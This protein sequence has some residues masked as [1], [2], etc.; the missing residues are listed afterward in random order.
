MRND[1]S[2]ADLLRVAYDDER[3]R[4]E[5]CRSV[6]K[7]WPQIRTALKLGP[8]HPAAESAVD[9]IK[10]ILHESRDS[11][12]TLTAKGDHG[13][14]PICVFGFDQLCTVWVPEFDQQGLF[15]SHDDA[16]DYACNTWSEFLTDDAVL[17]DRFPASR[18]ADQRAKKRAKVKALQT[19]LARFPIETHEYSKVGRDKY[20]R[21]PRRQYEVGP[22][23][24]GNQLAQ[25]LVNVIGSNLVDLQKQLKAT[26][27][28]DLI[29]KVER[30][31]A[32]RMKRHETEEA[33]GRAQ[34]TKAVVKFFDNFLQDKNS[35]DAALLDAAAHAWVWKGFD[36]DE[37][38]PDYEDR[39]GGILRYARQLHYEAL[40]AYLAAKSKN[41][42]A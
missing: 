21:H 19:P 41:N 27:W 33:K 2:D 31:A 42:K 26:G 4:K 35:T 16:I 32:Q 20:L 15:L 38:H 9:W 14:Y 39:A 36:L 11:I 40:N 25:S 6:G 34:F 3:L 1:H 5:L 8:S 17:L 22:P 30:I 18:A 7:E 13:E 24:T 29:L 12:A 28:E 37:N 10:Q 23:F